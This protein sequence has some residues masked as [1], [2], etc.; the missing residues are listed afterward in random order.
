MSVTSTITI[1]VEA[2]ET[3][4]I[5]DMVNMLDSVLPY[6]AHNVAVSSRTHDSA[7]TSPL[8]LPGPGEDPLVIT[9]RQQLR[10][11]RAAL[12]V[13]PDWHEPDEQE[14]DAEVVWNGSLDNA[15]MGPHCGEMG[16]WITQ[17]HRRVAWVNLAILFAFATG[18][19]G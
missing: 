12:G 10:D 3:Q 1:E 19:E 4:V 6:M 15:F 13:R 14:V 2:D 17:N 18:Y 5:R 11:L 9:T 7:D 16:V 8:A